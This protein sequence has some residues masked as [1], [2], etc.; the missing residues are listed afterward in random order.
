MVAVNEAFS[1]SSP[2]AERYIH[3][4]L[5][6]AREN[7]L[8]F[9]RAQFTELYEGDAVVGVR[10][11][12]SELG[13]LV[14]ALF[15]KV[16]KV[17]QPEPEERSVRWEFRGW[18]VKPQGQDCSLELLVAREMN[19]PMVRRRDVPEPFHGNRARHQIVEFA[20]SVALS[21]VERTLRQEFPGLRLT[22]AGGVVP[23]QAEG[24]LDGDP[25]YFRYRHDEARLGVGGDPVA[26]PL[27]ESS[28]PD[29][30]EF[31]DELPGLDAF[32]EA[33]RYLVPRLA[34]VPRG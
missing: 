22:S 17:V 1:P 6:P 8:A 32:V 4:V 5:Q 2:V 14:D 10:Y 15:V 23:F 18:S 24:T 34:P 7:P 3:G 33:M 27:F 28:V 25:F 11:V 9:S 29:G 12:D 30:G 20:H 16:V 19:E 13:V 26:H 21:S 31:F